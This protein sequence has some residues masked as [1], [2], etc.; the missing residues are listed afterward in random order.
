[1]ALSVVNKFQHN[2]LTHL[3][4]NG[5][6]CVVQF[7]IKPLGGTWRSRSHSVTARAAVRG[8]ES[9]SLAVKGCCFGCDSPEPA[10]CFLIGAAV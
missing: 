10:P 6:H 7:L 4:L 2:S 8:G 3:G 5:G 1:M 9:R